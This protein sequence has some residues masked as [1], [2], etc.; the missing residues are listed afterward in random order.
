MPLTKSQMA[1]LEKARSTGGGAQG[2][3]LSG[4]ECI[5]LIGVIAKDLSCLNCFP[6]I[7]DDVPDLFESHSYEFKYRNDLGVLELMDRLFRLNPD[8]DTYFASLAKLYK[9][10]KKFGRI[11]ATQS[12]SSLEQIAPRALLEFGKSKPSE[13]A[14]LLVWR[15]WMFDIDNRA[16]QET[17]YVFEPIIA[18]AI[19]GVSV[20]ARNSPIRRTRGPKRGRQVDCIRDNRAYEFKLRVTIA[21]SGQERWREELEF[22]QDCRNS[23]YVPVLLVL[24]STP[25]PKLGKL[26]Q[27]KLHQ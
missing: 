12:F 21:A 17:G 13:L 1:M 19:G 24:D 15:K 8:A 18:S 3:A 25:N 10:R 27:S 2:V 26:Y 9:A 6:E 5:Y 11:L 4:N 16:A 14:T 22:P 7:R 23:G 20:S